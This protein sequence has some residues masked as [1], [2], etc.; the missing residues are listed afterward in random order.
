MSNQTDSKGG[1]DSQKQL[2]VRV[3]NL[4]SVS[5]NLRELVSWCYEPSQPPRSRSG[6]NSE[7]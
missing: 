3:A 1:R 7:R 4:Y 2:K 6:L 5:L